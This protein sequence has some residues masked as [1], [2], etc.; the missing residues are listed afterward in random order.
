MSLY[1]RS[2]HLLFDSPPGESLDGY[3]RA[4]T[5]DTN[6]V[7]IIAALLCALICGLG[8]NSLVRYCIMR[9]TA[10][11]GPADDMLPRFCRK[12]LNKGLIR[13][14]PVA[15]FTSGEGVIDFTECPICLGEFLDG[16]KI[17]VLPKCHHCFHVKC[18]DI[19]LA[20]HSSCPT[21][22]QSVVEE[23]AGSGGGEAEVAGRRVGNDGD[24]PAEELA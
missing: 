2:R 12:G 8:I 9:C 4:E 19:W 3:G 15:V 1:H 14:I 7:I 23:Q 11:V 13:Q 22:R 5:F 16:E 17:R 20:S 24:G 18:V 6:M 21:C 10:G